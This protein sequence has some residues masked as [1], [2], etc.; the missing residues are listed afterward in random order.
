MAELA[1]NAIAQVIRQG[2]LDYRQGIGLAQL[3]S[4]PAIN[5]NT[6]SVPP[7]GSPPV[8]G[9]LASFGLAGCGDEGGV[10]DVKRL[11]GGDGGGQG[12]IGGGRHAQEDEDVIASNCLCEQCLGGRGNVVFV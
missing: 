10:R 2:I 6:T 8:A 4:P 3:P 5:N 9:N 1:C 12:G 11:A 7:W